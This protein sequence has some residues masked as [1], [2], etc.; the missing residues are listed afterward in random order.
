MPR[1]YKN[2]EN[3]ITVIVQRKRPK[4]QKVRD[5]RNGEGQLGVH[6]SWHK[7]SKT[8]KYFFTCL[9]LVHFHLAMGM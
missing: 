4:L 5:S 8:D 3:K 6:P 7:N 9:T 2:T 1:G